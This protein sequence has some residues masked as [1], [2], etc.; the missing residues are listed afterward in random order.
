MT[1]E[2]I[3]VIASVESHISVADADPVLVGFVLSL[4]LIVTFAGHVIAGGVLSVSVIVWLHDVRLPHSSIAVHVRIIMR[5]QAPVVNVLVKVTIGF[6][7]HKSV[8]VAVPV[9]AGVVYSLH[10]IVTSGG[11]ERTGSALSSIVMIC[12]TSI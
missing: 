8:A 3:N 4:Q 1:V 2:L 10:K 6:K 7:S 12:V 11:H 5:G 9:F